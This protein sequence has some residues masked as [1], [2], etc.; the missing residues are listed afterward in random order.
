VRRIAATLV[1]CALLSGCAST[2]APKTLVGVRKVPLSVAFEDETLTP[3]QVTRVIETILPP[4]PPLLTAATTPS[5]ALPSLPKAELCPA[6]EPGAVP[7]EPATFGISRP[8]KEGT[9]YKRN[10]GT[11]KVTG[12]IPI[13]LPYPPL[14]KVVIGNVRQAVVN[15]PYYGNETVTTYES[16][17]QLAPTLS[18]KSYYSYNPRELDLVAEEIITD[19]SVS[20]FAPTPAIEVVPFTGTGS[21]W[22]SAGIDSDKLISEAL[23]GTI[24]GAREV[25]DVC[26]KLVDTLKISTTET[27]VSFADG[28]VSGSGNSEHPNTPIVQNYALQFGALVI[29]RE[30]H[31]QRTLQTSGAPLTLQVDVVSSLLSIEPSASPLL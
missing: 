10:N 22:P 11:V 3:P 16:E 5:L 28:S 30:E 7:E 2:G 24:D 4:I 26:G 17:E 25:I 1:A 27:R 15:T 18:I 23:Q 21:T 6:A 12:A 9:Y 19:G 29:R 31:S 20:R 13:T 14:S 8:P